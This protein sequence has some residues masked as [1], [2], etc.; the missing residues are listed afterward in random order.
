M[1]SRLKQEALTNPDIK[2]LAHEE[3]TSGNKSAHLPRC[4]A[5]IQANI[6]RVGARGWGCGKGRQLWVHAEPPP[7]AGGSLSLGW[8]GATPSVHGESRPCTLTP[9]CLGRSGGKRGLRIPGSHPLETKRENC[10]HK[11]VDL[12]FFEKANKHKNTRIPNSG[13]RDP[14]LLFVSFSAFYSQT[15]ALHASA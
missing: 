2:R 4:S 3:H 14:C 11:P 15:L 9:C 13:P 7:R 8:S 10:K 12:Y 1:D 5:R 6:R